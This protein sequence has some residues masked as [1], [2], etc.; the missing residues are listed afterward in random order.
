M[1]IALI[2]DTSVRHK[3]NLTVTVSTYSF[4]L[5]L[6]GCGIRR[7]YIHSAPFICY[8]LLCSNYYLQPD[9]FSNRTFII[10]C[11]RRYYLVDFSQKYTQPEPPLASAS[12]SCNSFRSLP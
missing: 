6:S 2:I 8:S 11:T 3:S 7:S 12:Y 5:V 10:R 1:I 9:S 4:Q